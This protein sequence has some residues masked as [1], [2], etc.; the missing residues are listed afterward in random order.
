MHLRTFLT[1]ALA[2][3]LITAAPVS[4]QQQTQQSPSLSVNPDVLQEGGSASVS[5]S[6]SALAGQ[7]VVINVTDGR[8]KNPQTAV[9][10]IVLDSNGNG[11]ASWSV[12]SWFMATFNAPGACEVS[13]PICR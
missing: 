12:P 3:A 10:E 8:R 13:C 11:C 2:A 6:N 7:S 4:A 9:I 1:T 5:Y